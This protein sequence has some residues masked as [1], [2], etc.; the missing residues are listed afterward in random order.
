MSANQI[1]LSKIEKNIDYMER[2]AHRRL[3]H[4]SLPTRE[5]RG[6]I[7][8]YAFS[9]RDGDTA[10]LLKWMQATSNLKCSV[11]LFRGRYYYEMGI[12]SRVTAEAIEDSMFLF[13]TSSDRDN[14]LKAKLLNSIF[15]D[16][17][18]ERGAVSTSKISPPSR[19]DVF[20]AITTRMEEG[21]QAQT[22]LKELHRLS[23]GNVHGRASTIMGMYDHE[24]NRFSSQSVGGKNSGDVYMD[25][26]AWEVSIA[27]DVFGLVAGKWFGEHH[28]HHFHNR[29]ESQMRATLRKIP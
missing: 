5:L 7:E 1:I 4:I 3:K 6:Q 28:A 21:A 12:L 16:D 20:K 17:L 19:N 14:V 25:I 15:V 2:A 11:S 23:S 29:S 10:I 9:Q 18:D 22:L 13:L 26:L 24:S 8:T 27:L